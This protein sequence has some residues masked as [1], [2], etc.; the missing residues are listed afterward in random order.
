MS[1]LIQPG[2]QV[3]NERWSADFMSVATAD[4]GRLRIGNVVDDCS[5]QAAT[6]VERSI[7]ATRMT[8][9]LDAFAAENG[10]YPESM[11]LDNGPEFTSDTFDQWASSHG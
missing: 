3:V 5:R 8:E 9:R 2:T 11:T 4:S 6:I 1:V 10:G 7:P